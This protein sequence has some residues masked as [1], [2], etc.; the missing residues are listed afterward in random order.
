MP[1][2]QR[3]A[4]LVTARGQRSSYR[5]AMSISALWSSEYLVSS[6]GTRCSACY[7]LVWYR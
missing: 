6:H 7:N 5:N 1:L 3:F 4:E 2:S